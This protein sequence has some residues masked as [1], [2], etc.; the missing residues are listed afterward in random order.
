MAPVEGPS[1]VQLCAQWGHGLQ[2]EKSRMVEDT[3]F[4]GPLEDS[5]TPRTN[6]ARGGADE[7]STVTYH[8]SASYGRTGDNPP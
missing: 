8:S 1:N 7:G 6:A 3:V 2:R 5:Y 4:W